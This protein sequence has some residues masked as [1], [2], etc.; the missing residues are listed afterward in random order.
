MSEEQILEGACL[1]LDQLCAAAALEREWL[2]RRVEEGLIPAT[3]SARAEWRF[4]AIHVAR[5]R[6][7]RDI[8]RTY[9]A[10][11]ELAALVADMLEELDE[12]RARLRARRGI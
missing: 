2:V 7:M 12:L 11:P 9:E 3:G 8:E 6:R 10:A 1:T 4:A 5:A